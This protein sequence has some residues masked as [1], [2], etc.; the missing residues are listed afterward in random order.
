MGTFDS[1]LE[2]QQLD[3]AI[4]QL[5]YR[6][7]HLPEQDQLNDVVRRLTVLDTTMAPHR[8]AQGDLDRRQSTLEG[9]IHDIDSKIEA[10]SKQLYGGTVTSSRELQALE[11][12]IAS[13]KK[14]RS[15]LEDAELE[16]LMNREPVDAS[17]AAAMAD[18][19]KLDAEASQC[20]VAVAEA[21][22]SIDNELTDLADRRA[23]MAGSVDPIL[24][25]TYERIRKT[26]K[27]VGIARLEHGTCMSC[28]LKLSAVHLDALKKL[29]ETDLAFC[30]ECGAILVR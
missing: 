8:A 21:L 22:V 25:E 10:A 27:G 24:T 11:A 1:L 28:R 16:L 19:E 12:D 18:R 3:T 13:L 17:V 6:R 2:M 20:R 23:A 7:A 26:N 4:A 29:A 30:D 5:T 9:Q 14:H 15:E